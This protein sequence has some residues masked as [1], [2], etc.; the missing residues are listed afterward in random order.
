MKPTVW[1]DLTF[2]FILLPPLF[3]LLLFS[4]LFPSF[5]FF[6]FLFYS[7]LF[8]PFLFFYTL[9]SHYFNLSPT[10]F[11]S[12]IL[13]FPLLFFPPFS[14]SI[15]VASE[16]DGHLLI[17]LR[18]LCLLSLSNGGLRAT[19]FDLLRKLIIQTYGYKHLYTLC[20]FE[21]AGRHFYCPNHEI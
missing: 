8:F 21:K 16:R 18:L 11:F 2:I 19:R 20:N 12:F 14:P 3:S 17:V 4:F 13:S 10:F 7:F 5:L 15:T 6:S 1:C 9:S